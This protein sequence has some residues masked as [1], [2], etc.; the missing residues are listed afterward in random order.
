[1]ETPKKVGASKKPRVK[2]EIKRSPAYHSRAF[3]NFSYQISTA[4]IS[5][6]II[7]DAVSKKTSNG[8]SI[9]ITDCSHDI[10]LHSNL[11]NALDRQNALFK[12]GVIK[13]ECEKA[14]AHIEK[15]IN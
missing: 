6:N 10:Y 1:M 2:K 4:L 14:I 12:L 3:L 15:H 13:E 11:A 9:K 5:V 8:L 7:E